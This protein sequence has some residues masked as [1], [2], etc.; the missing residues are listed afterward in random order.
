MRLSVP[1]I[2][3]TPANGGVVDQASWYA[4][5]AHSDPPQLRIPREHRERVDEYHDRRAPDRPLHADRPRHRSSDQRA[6]NLRQSHYDERVGAH[7]PPSQMI[8]D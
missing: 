4:N 5:A 8:R 7:Q 2:T 6:N 1:Q 3:M